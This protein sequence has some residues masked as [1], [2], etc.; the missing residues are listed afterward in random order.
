MIVATAWQP[1]QHIGRTAPSSSTE[2]F[3]PGGIG[4][5]QWKQAEECESGESGMA[6]GS[7]FEN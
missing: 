4:S 6:A 5:P 3:V 2:S 7:G 1:A